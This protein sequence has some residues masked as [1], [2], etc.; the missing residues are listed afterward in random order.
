MTSSQDG[1]GYPHAN[2]DLP[3]TC[4]QVY[5]ETE[6]LPFSLHSFNDDDEWSLA[7]LA[8]QWTTTS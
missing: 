8:G 7:F 5:A 6:L 1:F 4:R 3:L 2:I